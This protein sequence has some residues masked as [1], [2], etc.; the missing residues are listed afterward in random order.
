MNLRASPVA[1]ETKSTMNS[2]VYSSGLSVTACR[3]PEL[4]VYK[5]L[6]VLWLS[7]SCITMFFTK[8]SIPCLC[9]GTYSRTE[10]LFVWDRLAAR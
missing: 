6:H 5:L 8:K 4:S 2:A 7:P 10:V 3:S 9:L 1:V